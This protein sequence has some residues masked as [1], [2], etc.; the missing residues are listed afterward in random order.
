MQGDIEHVAGLQ[1][2]QITTLFESISGSETFKA[3]YEKLEV[4][5][6]EAEEKLQFV[7]AKKKNTHAEKRQKKAQKEEAEKH[8]AKQQELVSTSARK[9]GRWKPEKFP[10]D[11]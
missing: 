8:I 6:K 7:L 11:P 5:K 3:D 10:K 4:A 2:S 9:A 1:P